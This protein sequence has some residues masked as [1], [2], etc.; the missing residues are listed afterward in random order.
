MLTI[1]GN[2]T[3]T[4]S[5][6]VNGSSDL[7]LTTTNSITGNINI[8]GTAFG[9]FT[10]S[11]GNGNTVKLGA[12]LNVDTLDLI[13][14]ILV[15]NGNN[16]SIS[17]DITAG[18]TGMILS[19]AISDISVNASTNVHGSLTFDVPSDS[20][21]NLT[22]NIAGGGSLELGSDLVVKGNLDL[23]AGFLDVTNNN[24]NI[25]INGTITGAGPNA[26]IITSGSG[27]LTMYV[28]L[29]NST[30]FAVGTATNY[31]PAELTLNPGSTTGTIGVNVSSGVYSQGTLG[32][33]ISTS[34][35]MVDATW[36][37]QN[38]ISSGLNTNMNL[39]W[40]A[41]A[42]V[43]GFVHTDDY[44]SHYESFWDDIGDSMTAMSS[45]SLYFV[46]RTNITSMSPFAVFDQQTVPTGMK[47]IVKNTGDIE[48]YPNPAY[49]NLYAK[50]TTGSNRLVY[51][52]IYNTLGQIVLRTQFKNDTVITIPVYGLATGSY[53]I[54]FYNDTMQVVKKF[55]KL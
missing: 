48:I 2:V 54:K 3:G 51:V 19:T 26:Y 33:E 13:S 41:S 20:V 49:E 9:K 35:P 47:E 14:G 31:F 52:E 23:M 6:V 15:L 38:N 27:N 45:G 12:N 10:V 17:G 16:V 25:G 50:N 28:N 11:I 55:S 53:I 22:I 42:E 36:L 1:S 18:G 43:N 7:T 30:T 34:Q 46:T 24:L 8:T 5:L 32:V 37:F 40:Q 29:S 39:Y 4:G 44:I 21:N